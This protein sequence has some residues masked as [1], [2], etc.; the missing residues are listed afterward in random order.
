MRNFVTRRNVLFAAVGLLFASL[1]VYRPA[2]AGIWWQTLF[3]WLHVPVFGLMSLALLALTPTAWRGRVRF[4]VVILIAMA[5]AVLSEAVQ[6]PLGRNASLKDIVSDA[7]GIASCLLLA[8]ARSHGLGGKI[9]LA[10][11]AVAILA[12]TTMPVVDIS[13]AIADRNDRFPVIFAGDMAAEREFVSTSGVM[14]QTLWDPDRGHV[15]TRTLL[16]RGQEPMINIRDLVSDWSAWSSLVLEFRVAGDEAIDF[17]VRVHDKA[18]RRGS[19]PY[20]DRF[21][22]HISA[23]PGWNALRI[24]LRDIAAAPRTRT[25]DMTSIEALVI[26]TEAQNTDRALDLYE[27]RLD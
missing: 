26:F 17:T 25:M 24:P 22:R 14:A 7:A 6:I 15:F 5:L 9:A 21:N 27:I 3:D 18:H 11:V 20:D 19:Q 23:V 13:R 4:G 1:I 8:H 12:W 16:V 10:T 2:Y